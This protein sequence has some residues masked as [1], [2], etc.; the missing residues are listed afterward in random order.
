[1]TTSPPP[2]RRRGDPQREPLVGD[3]HG[4]YAGGRGSLA[5]IVFGMLVLA[6]TP[7]GDATPNEV[8]FLLALVVVQVVRY[9]QHR[10]PTS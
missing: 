3:E 8:V 2:R 4:L 7:T 6:P 10:N 5:V 9:Q 1:M